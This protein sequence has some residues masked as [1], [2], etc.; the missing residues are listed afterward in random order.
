VNT[1]EILAKAADLIE[2]RGWATGWYVN[3]CGG[4][5]ARGAVYAAGGYEPEPRHSNGNWFNGLISDRDVMKAEA[6]LDQFVGGHAP[7]WNDATGRTPEQII[8]GLR[9]AAEAAGAET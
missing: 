2:E 7:N 3:D 4:L 9:R 8:F 6:F 5:C 1:S